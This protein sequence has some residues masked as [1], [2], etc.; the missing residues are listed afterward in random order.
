MSMCVLFGVAGLVGE[1]G[2][3]TLVG[4]NSMHS[5]NVWALPIPR[6]KAK[7]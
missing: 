3:G 2:M 1:R 4:R 7:V 6:I 5:L